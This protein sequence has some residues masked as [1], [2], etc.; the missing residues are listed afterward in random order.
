MRKSSL[1]IPAIFLLVIGS[2]FSAA[3]V[4]KKFMRRGQS[5]DRSLTTAPAAA[6]HQSTGEPKA[7]FYTSVGGSLATN[8]APNDTPIMS[9]RY[10]I[11]VAQ[12][13][14]QAEAEQLLL[15]MKS[16]GID[17][18]Y[19]PVRRGGQVIYRIRLGVYVSA[20]DAAKTLT[21]ITAR[22]QIK[23]QITKLQ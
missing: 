9:N 20:D 17:G 19:T 2:V 3:I 4:R 23:G 11:E 7:V 16:R 13:T 14:S 22:A 5:V 6:S 12:V 8:Q 18:F 15:Q 1:I 21:K 10:T